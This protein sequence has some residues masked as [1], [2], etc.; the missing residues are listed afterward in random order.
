MTLNSRCQAIVRSSPILYS[1]R[2]VY[3]NLRHRL[4]YA[5]GN[6]ATDSGRAHATR[7]LEESLEYIGRVFRDYRQYAGV[8][9]FHGRVAEVGP[10]D[11]CGVGVMFLQDG[12]THVDLVDKYFSRR[13]PSH[14]IA[15]I[16]SLTTTSPS[17]LK[18]HHGADGY[19]EEHV[20]GL[21]RYYGL[22]L[23]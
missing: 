3:T 11:S 15:I 7:S 1:T 21:S 9:Q 12:C 6:I 5:L 18:S 16:R 17:L 20:I 10:G 22:D 4:S 19:G 23:N 2:L 8:S 14:H 13:D